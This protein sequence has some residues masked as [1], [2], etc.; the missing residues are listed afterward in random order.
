MVETHAAVLE[1][2]IFMMFN[3][4]LVSSIYRKMAEK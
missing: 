4:L 1:N 3:D 2:M